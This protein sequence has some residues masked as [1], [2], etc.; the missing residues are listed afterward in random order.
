MPSKFGILLTRKM[1]EM[2]VEKATN[3][4]TISVDRAVLVLSQEWFRGVQEIEAEDWRLEDKKCFQ[5]WE[6]L[7]GLNH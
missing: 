5:G 1:G 4:S 2:T 7:L 6:R 3:V